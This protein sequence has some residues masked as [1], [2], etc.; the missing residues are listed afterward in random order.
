MR[1][2]RRQLLALGGSAVALASGA[3]FWKTRSSTRPHPAAASPYPTN[4]VDH[5]G[6]ML[7]AADKKKIVESLPGPTAPTNA[8]DNAGAP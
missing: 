5:R 2:S 6:W 8:S 1:L 7:T 3:A 4:V